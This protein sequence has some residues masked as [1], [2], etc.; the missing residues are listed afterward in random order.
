MIGLQRGLQPK[1]KLLSWLKR[2]HK[3]HNL[4]AMIIN[5]RNKKNV[6]ETSALLPKSQ[7]IY[8][9]LLKSRNIFTNFKSNESPS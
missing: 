9:L 8:I 5:R 4:V 1:E 2:S 6:L 3:K 7:N